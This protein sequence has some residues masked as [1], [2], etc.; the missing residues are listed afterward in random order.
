MDTLPTLVDTHK[1]HI[2]LLLDNTETTEVTSRTTAGV[3]RKTW[4]SLNLLLGKEQ[5]LHADIA[6]EEKF[7]AQVLTRIPRDVARIA[8]VSSKN[9]SSLLCPHKLKPS[10]QLMLSTLVCGIW[11]LD[12]MDVLDQ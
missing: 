2:E 3:V 11:A 8:N 10:F 1:T 4:P 6:G 12:L 7:V 9:V 5:R